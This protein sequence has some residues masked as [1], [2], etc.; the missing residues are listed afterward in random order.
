MLRMDRKA[1]SL[2]QHRELSQRVGAEQNQDSGSES[3]RDNGRGEG[4]IPT[5]SH[6][7]RGMDLFNCSKLSTNKTSSSTV[8][9]NQVLPSFYIVLFI[10]GVVLNGMA[11]WIF[12]RV[13][14][15]SALVVYLKNMVVADLLMLLSFPVR[16]AVKMG[17]NCCHLWIFNCQ[18]N[19]VL[20][21]MSMYVGMLFIGYI[22]LERYVKIS[23]HASSSTSTSSFKMKC[24]GVS[25]LNLMQNTTFA[26]VL[27]VL[28]W[29]LLFLYSAPNAMLATWPAKDHNFTK[30]MQLKTPLGAQW[31]RVSVLINMSLFSVT[32]LIVGFS[33]TFI[34]YQV[35]KTYR[36]MR[37]DSRGIY[38]NSNRNIFSILA[39]FFVCFVPYHVCRVPYTMSQMSSS[40]FSEDTS[41]LLH[42]I[43]EGTLFLSVTNVCLNPLIYFLMCR[44][45]RKS[46]IRKLSSKKRRKSLPTNQ[47]PSNM[48]RGGWRNGCKAGGDTERED[49]DRVDPGRGGNQSTADP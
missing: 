4:P 47:S 27:A 1:D 38:R 6:A 17:F 35:Y 31:H 40:S 43:K 42:Q 23:Q 7:A 22:S 30:C 18:F 20:F 12:F 48:Q 11:A 36:C 24:S 46:L 45:F 49:K 34:A 13:P 16:V 3:Q 2:Q 25:D 33:Y 37:R 26:Q 15:D 32:L 44:N 5:L 14:A 39:V 9:T 8:F 28:T 21:Y 29:G 41:I 10:V 19:A